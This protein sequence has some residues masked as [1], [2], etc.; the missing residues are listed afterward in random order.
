M[1]PGT[2]N[3]YNSLIDIKINGKIFKIFSLMRAEENGLHGF[4]V[5]KITKGSFRK[6][7]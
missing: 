2:K 7:S 4:Q 6:S 1:K 3:S 5:T